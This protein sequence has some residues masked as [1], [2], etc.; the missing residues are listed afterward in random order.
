[1]VEIFKYQNSHTEKN[2][3]QQRENEKLFSP[4]NTQQCLIKI[5]PHRTHSTIESRTKAIRPDNEV[6]VYVGGSETFQFQDR[7]TLS[8]HNQR[9]LLLD[10]KIWTKVFRWKVYTL[11][12]SHI[13]V[14]LVKLWNFHTLCCVV[15]RVE[16][17]NFLSR[18]CVD[19]SSHMRS[20]NILI[21]MNNNST[22]G[23]KVNII[24]FCQRISSRT[25]RNKQQR[26]KSRGRAEKRRK[27]FS[28]THRKKSAHIS[29]LLLCFFCIICHQERKKRGKFHSWE[30]VMSTKFQ[31][32]LFITQILPLSRL[33]DSEQANM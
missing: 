22:T 20:E 9:N 2:Q 12:I 1:M 21:W 3:Q 13:D 26:R 10:G 5:S 16:S 25:L 28:A 4:F 14:R 27:M 31:F 17:W 18:S 6:S 8:C 11:S 32:L 7:R 33:Y 24:I 29:L 15:C 23:S 19:I 30:N